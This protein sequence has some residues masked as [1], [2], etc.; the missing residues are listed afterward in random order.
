MFD[1]LNNSLVSVPEG[2]ICKLNIGVN[3][4]RGGKGK[5]NS[6]D[7]HDENTVLIITRKGG[8]FRSWC[9]SVRAVQFGFSR[10]MYVFGSNNVCDEPVERILREG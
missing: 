7:K 9:E 5:E 6:K 3:V 8:V 4:K 1:F 10:G 2:K